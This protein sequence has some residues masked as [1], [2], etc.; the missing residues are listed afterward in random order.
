M[1]PVPPAIVSV[2]LSISIVRLPPLSPTTVKSSSVPPTSIEAI[3][4]AK[5]ELSGVNEP[6]IFDLNV[7]SVKSTLSVSPD[8]ARPVPP[9][10]FVSSPIS[11]AFNVIACPL[12]E[13]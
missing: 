12:I 8:N 9:V 6:D 7:E 10:K 13:R 2:S 4:P 5:D 11:I 3:L 1:I